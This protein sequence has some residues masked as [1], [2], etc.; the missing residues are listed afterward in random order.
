MLVNDFD[1]ERTLEEEEAM[2]SSEDAQ[3]ELDELHKVNILNCTLMLSIKLF[4]MNRVHQ[5]M[6][7]RADSYIYMVSRNYFKQQ[8]PRLGPPK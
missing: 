6:W 3:N 7:R 2:E 8:R 4:L 1:D 5:K